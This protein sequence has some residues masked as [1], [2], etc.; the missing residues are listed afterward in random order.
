[1]I[2]ALKIRLCPT[3]KQAQVLNQHFGACRFVYNQALNFKKTEYELY[4][5]KYS[6]FD[7]VNWSTQFRN[8]SGFPWLQDIKCEVIQNQI[9]TLDFA[10][11]RFYKGA[12]YPKFKKK[13]NNQSF[14]SKQN[15]KIL[16]NTNKIFFFK[17]RIKFKCSLK[18]STLLRTSTIKRVTYSKDTCNNYWA[19]VQIEFMPEFENR[20]LIT[21]EIGIDLGLKEFLVTSK[22]EHIENP[23]FFRKSKNKLAKLQKRHSRKKKNSKNREKAR[24][25]VAKC[26]KKITN[27]RKHFFHNLTN[28]LLNENQVISLE[29]LQVKNMVKNHNL[30]LSIQDAAWSTFV[31]ILEYKAIWRGAEIRRID[32][33]LPSSKTC[34]CCG[35]IKEDLTLANRVYECNNCGLVI[36]RDE[37]AAINILEF[38]KDIKNL[39]NRDESTRINATGRKLNRV[40]K[41]VEENINL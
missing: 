14:V 34:S 41:N 23:R 22:G 31:G 40:R 19:S 4:K 8:N 24:L 7:M 11:K 16:E 37:N 26:H 18:Y 27:Q 33:F 20:T 38:S 25:K 21:P 29:S 32:T 28:K 35:T 39:K 6:K 13:S 10:F 15:F 36:D 5:R 12:G 3:H 17:N 30:A 9:D 1:M 2:K